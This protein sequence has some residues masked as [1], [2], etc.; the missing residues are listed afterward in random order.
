M[1]IM[2]SSVIILDINTNTVCLNADTGVSFYL[3]RLRLVPLTFCRLLLTPPS[4][5]APHSSH[6]DKWLFYWTGE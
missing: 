2:Q 5:A 6:A 4:P 3:Y 1:E